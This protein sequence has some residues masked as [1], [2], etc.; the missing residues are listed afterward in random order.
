M[1]TFSNS[2]SMERINFDYS[3]KNIPL[4]S[5]AEYVTKLIEKTEH[6]CRRLRW[7]ALFFLNPNITSEEKETY[8][9]KSRKTP[10]RLPETIGFENRLLNMIK[11][12]KF[13][14]PKCNFLRKMKADIKQHIKGTDDLLVAADKTTNYYRVDK[15][16]YNN[17]LKENIT[18]SYSKVSEN[19]VKSIAREAKE[20]ASALDI[21]DRVD[22]TA[23]NQAFITLKDHKA[24]FANKPSCRLINPTKSELGIVSKKII[25]RINKNVTAGLSVNQWRNTN[26]VINW[27]NSFADKSDCRFIAFYVIE[28][29][30]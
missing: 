15:N 23:Q 17:L 21:D 16:R 6:F 12:I 24:N 2:L 22:S 14:K 5:E 9:F 3:I 11:N 30:P 28:F 8:G 4:P 26:D 20:L 18:K 25:E 13:R 29:Y 27:F 1:S 10:P 19:T 7:K